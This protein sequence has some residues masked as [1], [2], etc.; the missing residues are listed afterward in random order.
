MKIVIK[1]FYTI[2]FFILKGPLFKA[3]A[4]G[5][6]LEKSTTNVK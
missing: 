4:L 6:R 3:T 2:V 5:L 1:K